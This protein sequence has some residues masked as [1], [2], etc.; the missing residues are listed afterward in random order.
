MKL[1]EIARR[2]WADHGL[3]V[4]ERFQT[5]DGERY[6]YEVH[7]NTTGQTGLARDLEELKAEIQSL[8]REED[9]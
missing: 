3:I 7:S 6:R 4:E 1:D 8:A 9:S 2:A 5:V